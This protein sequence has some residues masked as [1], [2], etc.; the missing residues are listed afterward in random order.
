[1]KQTNYLADKKILVT[2]GAGFL[3]ENVVKILLDSTD[4]QDY[5]INAELYWIQ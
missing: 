4:G 5:D 1:M 3:G 2:G